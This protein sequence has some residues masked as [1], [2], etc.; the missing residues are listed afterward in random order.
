MSVADAES[1][2][3]LLPVKPIDEQRFE[4]VVGGYA[5]RAFGGLTL[6]CAT[7]AVARSFP[8]RALV[9]VHAQFVRPL[10]ADEAVSIEI[11]ILSSGRRLARR[12]ARIEFDSKLA[13]ELVATFG[14]PVPG[15]DFSSEGIAASTP[16]PDGLIADVE[17]ARRE[18][19][20]FWQPGVIEWRWPGEPY[21][22][23]TPQPSRYEAWVRPRSP[24]PDERALRYAALAYLS[25][26]MSHWP[27]ARSLGGIFD[28]WGYVSL[29]QTL[30]FHRDVEW[31]GWWHMVSETHGGHGGRALT[32]RRLRTPNG[33]LAVSMAQEQLIPGEPPQPER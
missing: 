21:R 29:D 14:D 2:E 28:P 30:W 24:L 3:A 11:E 18:G 25:D 8:E 7:L 27:V 5:G 17:V 13:F 31:D 6:G 16:Q 4:A 20:D 33:Q 9:S 22:V 10:P 12:R 26:V 1:F 23:D 32:H 19:W 15:A